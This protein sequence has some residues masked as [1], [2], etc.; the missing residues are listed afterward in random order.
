ML[1]SDDNKE[2]GQEKSIP[3]S[4]DEG[5]AY[6]ISI[7]KPSKMIK[8]ENTAFQQVMMHS[9]AA[10]FLITRGNWTGEK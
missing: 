5:T 9:M 3:F 8:S 6:E 2:Q 1:F 4:Y 10:L 7:E